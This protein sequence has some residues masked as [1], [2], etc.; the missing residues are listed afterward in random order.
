MRFFSGTYPVAAFLLYSAIA[1]CAGLEL[2]QSR[3][4][5]RAGN[6][7][8]LAAPRETIDFLLNAKSRTV[9]IDGAPGGIVAGPNRARDQVL[10]AASTRVEPGYV[11]LTAIGETGEERVT[12]FDV[13]VNAA[14]RSQ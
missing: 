13:V 5:L 4:E 7:V 11:K 12:A 3:Y 2:Q 10:L 8:A 9:E 6:P 1:Q 14:N